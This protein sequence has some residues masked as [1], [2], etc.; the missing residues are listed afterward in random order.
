[1]GC[2]PVMKHDSRNGLEKVRIRGKRIGWMETGTLQ[3][4]RLLEIVFVDNGQGDGC[5]IVTPD[6]VNCRRPR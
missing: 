3:C 4:E 6:D 5:L 1:M 2:S